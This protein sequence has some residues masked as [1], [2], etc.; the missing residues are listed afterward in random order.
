MFQGFASH[1]WFPTGA[2]ASGA[3]ATVTLTVLL[4]GLAPPASA[5]GTPAPAQNV[6]AGSR[7]FGEKGCSRCHA[8]N[9]LGGTSGPDLSQ[10]TT[11][12][13][14]NGF[15]AAMWNHLPGMSAGMA[16][17][18]IQPPHLRERETGDLI[19]FLFWVNYFNPTGDAEEGRRIFEEKGCITCHQAGGVGGV[20]GPALDFSGQN[21]SPIHLAAALWNHGSEM[22]SAMEARGIQRPRFLSTELNDLL[23]YL[24]S[25]SSEAPVGPVYVLPGRAET[26]ERLFQTKNCS[27]CHGIRGRGGTIG[28]DLAERP[29]RDLLEFAATLWNKEPAMT[30][31]MRSTGIVVPQ[32]TPEDMADLVAYLAS[33][34]YLGRQG[35][36]A[37]GQQLLR[38]RGCV[39]CH[40]ADRRPDAAAGDL[41][42]VTELTTPSAV[43]AALWNHV[44]L[45]EVSGRQAWPSL[46]EAQVT[47]LVAYFA[48]QD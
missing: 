7:V 11:P 5:Q 21:K 32:L 44:T 3:R 41:A 37:R 24:G 23:A 12:R 27:R 8:I 28:P 6:L 48:S 25:M 46:D 39:A 43:I 10:L 16:A 17:L 13:S 26:G 36:A 18:G 29:R 34:Q 22:T 14:V 33:V 2:V 40:T 20:T 15:A 45:P 30:R 38:T 4:T 9:G 42:R 1:R 19:A 35:S 47:D 31:A